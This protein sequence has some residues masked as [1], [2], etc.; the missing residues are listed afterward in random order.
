MASLSFRLKI[1]MNKNMLFMNGTSRINVSGAV[2]F[3]CLIT[4]TV[5]KIMT[6]YLANAFSL[7]ML[8]LNGTNNVIVKPVDKSEIFDGNGELKLGIVSAVGHADTAAVLGVPMNRINVKLEPGDILYVAQLTGGRL[9]EG[10][11][12]LPEGFAFKFMKVKVV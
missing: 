12:T 5:F 7:Q 3:I 9:P 4:D 10:S 11:T 8:D 1:A 2:R 6:E